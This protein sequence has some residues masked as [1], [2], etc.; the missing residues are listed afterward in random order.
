MFIAVSEQ[1]V[2]VF[3]LSLLLSFPSGRIT[4]GPDRAP[5]MH[6]LLIPH[7]FS[8]LAGWINFETFHILIFYK[9]YSVDEVTL[10]LPGVRINSSSSSHIE[11][12]FTIQ[13][14][15]L[16]PSR[17]LNIFEKYL[18]ACWQ[19]RLKKGMRSEK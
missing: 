18:I 12:L 1:V 7:P 10:H 8:L 3:L 19:T 15:E 2:T 17:F 16:T 11:I 13:V 6:H 14:A 9:V 5:I 4:I